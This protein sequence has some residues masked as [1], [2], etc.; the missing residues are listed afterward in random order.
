MMSEQVPR[1]DFLLLPNSGHMP[2]YD[3]KQAFFDGLLRWLHKVD[4]AH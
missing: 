1:G 3:D 2:M 4:E